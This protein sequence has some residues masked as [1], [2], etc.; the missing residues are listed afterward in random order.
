MNQVLIKN[1]RIITEGQELTGD[2]H[3]KDG[4]INKID[5]QIELSQ[6]LRYQEIDAAGAV[7]MPGVIDGHVHFRDPGLT[8]KGNIASESR[9]AVAGGVT[10]FMDMPNTIPNTVT[11]KA[12]EEKYSLAANSSVANYS[13][14]MGLTRDNLEEA[15]KVGTEDVC[16]LTDDG[17]YFDE[18]HSLLCNNHPYL[19][20][21]FSRT[22]H[23]VALHSEDESIMAENYKRAH[24]EFGEN[25]PAHYHSII[26]DE[27]ACFSSTNSLV[28][29]ANR[30]RNR[31]HVLHVSTGAEALLFNAKPP[32]SEKRITSEVCV[33][34]LIFSTDDY[35]RLGNKI[36]WNPSV[37][38]H[39]NPSVL[40]QALLD[41][42][43]DMVATDHAP[44][45]WEEKQGVYD[46][47][48]PGGPMIQHSLI[49]LL[50]FY[51]DKKL[52]LEQIVSKTS[53]RVAEVYRIKE[54]G[55]IKE[56]YFA[57]LV[58][59]DLNNPWQITEESLRYKCGWSPLVGNR[60]RS[61]IKATLV[62]GVVVFDGANV[63]DEQKGKRLA[64]SK[65]R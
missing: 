48:K 62:N 36:K 65:I 24:E 38:P 18:N 34:H 19:E 3:I 28:E 29:L 1:A 21:L 43:I 31:L 16:G 25:I 50:E 32:T 64:F 54:R 17:L 12:L 61:K 41:D 59:V 27:R 46:Q 58:L 9:A 45:S 13:F 2:V 5:R 20:K 49:M 63:I 15:L 6:N 60:V 37:K 40:L 44:H 33:H 55:F 47:V 14:F 51:H 4:R 8:Y 30:F 7:L 11:V 52:T 26:R 10:S 56:G 53:H 39:N 42:H 22:D 35:S 57:D 23:L